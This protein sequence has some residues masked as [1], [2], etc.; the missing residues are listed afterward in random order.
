M[1]SFERADHP[2]VRLG[3]NLNSPI[4]FQSHGNSTSSATGARLEKAC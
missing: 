1:A 2:S 3:A 4:L